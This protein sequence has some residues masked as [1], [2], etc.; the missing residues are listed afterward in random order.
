MRLTGVHLLLSYACTFECDHCFVWSSPRQEGTMTLD[1]VRT[2]LEQS[3]R[4]GSVEWIY[5]EGGEPFL[6]YAALLKSVFDAELWS[7]PS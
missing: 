7:R 3:K 4:M 6:Y 2:I 5:F 1:T